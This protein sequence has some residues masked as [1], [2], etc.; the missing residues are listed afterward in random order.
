MSCCDNVYP[1]READ[2]ISK[3]PVN[4][5]QIISNYEIKASNFF[6]VKVTL[7]SNLSDSIQMKFW[8]DYQYRSIIQ[9]LGKAKALQDYFIDSSS[10]LLLIKDW[11]V[12]PND[13]IIQ[14]SLLQ[15]RHESPLAQLLAKSR[16][17]SLSRG[18]SNGM[19]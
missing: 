2:L 3:N 4:Y 9:D 14:L 6:A 17:S 1:E 10:Q 13:L 18:I 15:K 11:V 7:L 5:Q 12:V 19:A 16:L 8:K